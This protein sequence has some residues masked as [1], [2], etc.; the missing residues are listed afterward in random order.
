MYNKEEHVRIH[1]IPKR[2]TSE[3]SSSGVWNSSLN[4]SDKY[5][6][7]TELF[8]GY[9]QGRTYMRFV[10]SHCTTESFAMKPNIP[11]I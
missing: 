4:G 7:G 5:F 2:F 11:V 3:Y 6:L 10:G 1:A 8:N 9:F